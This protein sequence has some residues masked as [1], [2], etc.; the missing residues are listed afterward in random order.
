MCLKKK[1]K[2]FSRL[3]A[4]YKTKS[5]RRFKS[6]GEHLVAVKHRERHETKDRLSFFLPISFSLSLF[7]FFSLLFVQIPN[8]PHHRSFVYNLFLIC[9]E[10]GSTLYRSTRK[11]RILLVTFDCGKCFLD[12]FS[13]QAHHLNDYTL[14]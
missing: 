4:T 2:N 5:F 9:H 3:K 7:L 10:R 12:I 6:K 14:M 13:K 1:K 11:L 8:S